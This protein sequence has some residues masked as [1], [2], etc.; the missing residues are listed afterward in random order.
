MPLLAG[1]DII[2]TSSEYLLSVGA[3]FGPA[4][5]LNGEIWRLFT[6]M[7]LHGGLEHIAMNMLSLWFVGRVVEVWFNKISYLSIYLISGV[8]GGLI[9]IY[10]HP[11]TVGIGASGAIFGIFGAMAGIVI[12]HRKRMEAQFKAFIRDFGVILLLNLVI[13]VF[14][15]SVDLSAHIAG[16]ITGI[17]GGTMVGKNPK[18]IWLF[19]A[20]MTIIM[21]LIY[22]Y[23]PSLYVTNYE[24]QYQ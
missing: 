1:V 16:L 14:F 5:V 21:V 11:V 4:V 9:S 19:I 20:I 6:A 18:N 17:I 7:F 2:D 3:M 10:M 23:L 24:L 8:M 22:S 12:V 15:E 13:G